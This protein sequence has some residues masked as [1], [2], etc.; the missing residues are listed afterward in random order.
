MAQP[1]L[2]RPPPTKISCD[3]YSWEDSRKHW[4]TIKLD[5]KREIEIKLKAIPTAKTN[6]SPF[7]SLPFEMREKII[8]YCVEWKELVCIGHRG[9]SSRF[10][11][12]RGR[13]E[14]MPFWFVECPTV[15]A[16][17]RQ[18]LC[19]T[20][21]VLMRRELII[22]PLQEGVKPNND[23]WAN[24]TVVWPMARLLKL[25]EMASWG[26]RLYITPKLVLKAPD[27]LVGFLWTPLREVLSMCRESMVYEQLRIEVR[28]EPGD[29]LG[30]S[31]VD[32]GTERGRVVVVQ[33]DFP[34][35]LVV[36]SSQWASLAEIVDKKFEYSGP[37]TLKSLEYSLQVPIA[38]SKCMSGRILKVQVLTGVER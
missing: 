14:E 1:K 8:E 25:F 26:E 34:R 31:S 15:L 11:W 7:L 13:L 2:V 9:R 12:P 5:R 6:R 17:N 37:R 21:R 4:R 35:T 27:V 33:E 19:E 30:I 16:L 20:V 3:C 38:M 10:S 23:E 29:I 24:P 28:H 22:A 32:V 36:R 18:I